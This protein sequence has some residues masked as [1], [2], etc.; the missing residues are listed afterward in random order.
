VATPIRIGAL[1]W[2]GRGRVSSASRRYAV[3]IA[4]LTISVARGEFLGVFGERRALE[5]IPAVTPRGQR[6]PPIAEP[7]VTIRAKRQAQMVRPEP[8]RRMESPWRADEG[9]HCYTPTMF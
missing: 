2:K 9:Q 6:R 7:K 5:D 1:T 3:V 4:A 8:G